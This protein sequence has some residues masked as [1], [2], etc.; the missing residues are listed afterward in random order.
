MFYDCVVCID[1]FAQL[2]CLA[3]RLSDV[4][5]KYADGVVPQLIELPVATT[6]WIVEIK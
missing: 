1:G 4:K 6:S 2:H 3:A 5:P